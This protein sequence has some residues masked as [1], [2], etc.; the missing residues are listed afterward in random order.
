MSTKK[1]LTVKWILAKKRIIK[2]IEEPDTTYDIDAKVENLESIKSNVKINVKIE[3]N[4]VIEINKESEKKADKKEEQKTESKS[5]SNTTDANIKT[6]TIE[7]MTS[8]KDVVKFKEGEVNWYVVAEEIIPQFKELN[9]GDIVSI[10]VGKVEQKG[11]EKD[12]VIAI[13]NAVKNTETPATDDKELESSIHNSKSSSI[14][15]QCALKSA[16]E[17]V[18]ALLELDKIKKD[19]IKTTIE[20]LTKSCYQAIQKA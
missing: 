16:T 4:K 15:K 19:D 11:K 12:G 5:E 20:D 1:E 13:T 10:Q 6:W 9:K 18:V 7:A 2:F 17:I 8:S 14:E 3:D